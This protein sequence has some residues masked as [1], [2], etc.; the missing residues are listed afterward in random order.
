MKLK[1]I[2]ISTLAILSLAAGCTNTHPPNDNASNDNT[3]LGNDNTNTE[4]TTPKISGFY[5]DYSETTL[6]QAQQAGQKVVLFFNA[7]WCPFCRAA[8]I[9]FKAHTNKIPEGITL[10]KLNYDTETELKKKYGVTY[11]HTFVQIDSQGNLVTKWVSGDT[12][13]L[14]ANIK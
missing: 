5:K 8:D 4:L 6:A 12:A 1:K 9:D 11:Q 3:A 7:I 14:I 2:F 10:L 13:K